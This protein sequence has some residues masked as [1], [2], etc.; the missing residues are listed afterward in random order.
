MIKSSATMAELMQM[1]CGELTCVNQ[2]K[3]MYWMQS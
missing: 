3:N 1:L 2:K